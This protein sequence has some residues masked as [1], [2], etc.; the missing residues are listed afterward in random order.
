MHFYEFGNRLRELKENHNQET[1]IILGAEEDIPYEVLLKVI[2]HSLGTTA[3]PLFP[4]IT[5]TRLGPV[6]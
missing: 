2:D 3:R 6:E 1:S 5:L 4:D